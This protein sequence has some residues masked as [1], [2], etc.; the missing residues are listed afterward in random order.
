MTGAP[1]DRRRAPARTPRTTAATV[2]AFLA[3]LASLVP[4]VRGTSPRAGA[5]VLSR[6]GGPLVP[7]S[8]ALFGAYVQPKQWT[9]ASQKAAVNQLE[10]D[11]GRTLDISNHYYPWETPFPVWR[12]SWDIAS[13][14]IPMISWDGTYTSDIIDGSQD[15]LIKARA[16]AVKA[17][18]HKVFIRF[19]WEMDGVKKAPLVGSPSDFIAA[20][21][22]IH[23]FFERRG[24]TNAVWVWCPNAW[25]FENG[26]APKYYPGD[27]VVDWICAD[28]YN[29]SPGRPWEEW[30]PFAQIFAAFYD[31]G[32]AK[33]SKPMMVGET[34]AQEA[35]KAGKKADWIYYARTRLKDTLPWI[36]AFVYFDAKD[37]YDWRVT[38]STSAYN[39]FLRM[40]RDA[41]FN[42]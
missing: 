30:R 10:N 5:Q 19:F 9:K 31:W 11:M 13:G 15:D 8:G 18:G 7:S 42:T 39:A 2:V 27:D 14:R 38:T 21:R 33:G 37:S 16:D 25:G 41:Y 23:A 36:G 12:E 4:A 32:L 34:G 20:W 3:L 22:R 17:L 1:D 26:E 35:A 24:A 40:G 6:P 29:W 28:G